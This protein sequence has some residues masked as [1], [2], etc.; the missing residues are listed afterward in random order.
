MRTV[1]FFVSASAAL[2]LATPSLSQVLPD[3]HTRRRAYEH[4]M[5]GQEWLAAERWDRAVPEFAAAVKLHPLLTDA[6]YGLGQAYMGLRRYTSAA[7]AYQQCLEATRRLHAL[8]ER[9]RFEDDRLTLE[10]ADEIRDTVRRR[11]SDTLRG[12][13]LDAYVARLLATRESLM[14]AYVPP[15]PVL[16]ALG[17]AHFRAGNRDRA[18]YYWKEAARLD[19]SLGEAWNNLAAIYA[20]TARRTE[21]EDALRNAERAGYRVSPRLKE[22]IG[23]LKR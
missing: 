16:L 17:S 23:T 21:A 8:R 20:S 15:P 19:D 13:Q 9:A 6:Y 7:L 22:A 10:A 11:G 3:E 2:L 18:E 14:D 1:V 5:N 4:Y 12:R